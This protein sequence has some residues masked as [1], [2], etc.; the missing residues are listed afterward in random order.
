MRNAERIPNRMAASTRLSDSR[1]DRSVTLLLF[2]LVIDEQ[3]EEHER[4][5]MSKMS[6]TEWAKWAP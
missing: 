6:A 5:R 4:Y 2:T 3:R 1:F